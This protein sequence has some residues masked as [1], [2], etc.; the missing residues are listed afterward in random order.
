MDDRHARVC[1]CRKL[2]VSSRCAQK[3]RSLFQRRPF[4]SRS[5]T[6]PARRPPADH[7]P[8]MKM[9]LN[10]G[11]STIAYSSMAAPSACEYPQYLV[12]S[13][14]IFFLFGHTAEEHRGDQLADGPDHRLPFGCAERPDRAARGPI[15]L[16]SA[17]GSTSAKVTC[18]IHLSI[19]LSLS[20]QPL[21][22]SECPSGDG[23]HRPITAAR[24]ELS[25][26]MKAW[27][28]EARAGARCSSA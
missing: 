14:A 6:A 9:A 7:R 26:A 13:R 24:P 27:R 22:S 21:D 11:R 3:C 8:I 17:S 5:S 12:G 20:G 23:R 18:P 19:R 4:P 25:C 15:D 1:S 10:A 16:H 28:A 2:Q